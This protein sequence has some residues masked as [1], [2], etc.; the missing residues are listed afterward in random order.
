MSLGGGKLTGAAAGAAAMLSL[1]A[2]ATVAAAAGTINVVQTSAAGDRFQPLPSLTWGADFSAPL[3]VTVNRSA[4]FQTILGFG[5]A[6]T[7]SAAYN[8]AQLSAAGQAELLAAYWGP[9]SNG[10]TVG[11]VPMNSPDFALSTYSEDNSTDDFTLQYFDSSVGRDREYILPF[12]HAATA[13]AGAPLNLFLS[14][15]SPPAWMKSNNDMIGSNSPG[16]I[17]ST[18]VYSAWANYY[19]KFMDA[20]AAQGVDFW[21]LTV[22][23]E[24]LTNT[25]SHYEACMYTGS[26]EGAFVRDYLGPALRASAHAGAKLMI[27]DHNKAAAANFSLEILEDPAAAAFVDGTALHWYDYSTGLYLTSLQQIAAANG[28]KF[29][30]ATEAC[31]IEGAGVIQPYSVGELYAI[32]ILGDLNYLATGWTDWNLVL[33]LTGGPN[34][35]STAPTSAR[36]SCVTR[37]TTR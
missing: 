31:W 5:G 6:F 28:S 10:Y 9:G 19:V 25:G 24:P 29:M 12:I 26:Q 16:L 34:H 20:Y 8:F 32:D 4:V 35:T 27:Y 14:P 13:Q 30:L 22:Q 17:N 11:R 23:N 1:A 2:V 7:E 33:D 3:D 21:G 18:Q 15:W 37:R 36:P